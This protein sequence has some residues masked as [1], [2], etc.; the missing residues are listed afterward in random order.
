MY[1]LY[2][3]VNGAELAGVVGGLR[4]ANPRLFCR[5]ETTGPQR[6]QQPCSQ[7]VFTDMSSPL[8]GVQRYA[9]HQ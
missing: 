1:S 3:M 2:G 5:F 6:Y 4:G 7:E 9:S 8:R